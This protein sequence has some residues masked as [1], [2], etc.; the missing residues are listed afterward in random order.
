MSITF[1]IISKRTKKRLWYGQETRGVCNIYEDKVIPLRDFLSE[2][3]KEDLIDAETDELS[4]LE[5]NL[6]EYEEVEA[7]ESNLSKIEIDK[8]KEELL[9]Y[10]F[11]YVSKC[12]KNERTMKII[13]FTK[14]DAWFEFF[15]EKAG[16]SKEQIKAE[17]EVHKVLDYKPDFYE[18]LK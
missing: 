8:I 6:E 18:N 13:G 10:N 17:I 3:F 11:H 7:I 16:K 15:G 14:M 5:I 4:K 12:I 2:S 9:K 1:E